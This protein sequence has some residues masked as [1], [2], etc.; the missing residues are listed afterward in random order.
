[1]ALSNMRVEPRR[2]WT[3]QLLGLAGLC[4]LVGL[5]VWVAHLIV[6]HDVLKLNP[7]THY[8]GE[9]LL[10]LLLLCVGVGLLYFAALAVWY[11]AHELGEALCAKLAR[12]GWDP[13]PKQRYARVSKVYEDGRVEYSVVQVPVTTE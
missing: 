5:P 3:E 1:M 6:V 8:V 11:G 13:R 9:L 12:W 2:E 7:Q 10:V 4:V